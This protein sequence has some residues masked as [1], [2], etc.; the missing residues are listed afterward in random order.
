MDNII[1]EN[2]ER[3]IQTNVI[4]T[5]QEFFEISDVMMNTG[6]YICRGHS[7][8]KWK[9]QPS[10]LRP[11]LLKKINL[12]DAG[13][14][15]ESFL[16]VHFQDTYKHYINIALEKDDYTSILLIMQHY[17]IPTRLLDWTL[18]PQTALFFALNY[19]IKNK[20]STTSAAIWFLNPIIY[21]S[22]YGLPGGPY[23][24]QDTPDV[25]RLSSLAFLK[26]INENIESEYPVIFSPNSI[27]PRIIAQESIFSVHGW[28]SKAFEDLDAANEFLRCIIIK[29]D[30]KSIFYFI[31]NV[32][33][34][35]Y[36]KY[37]PDIY[38]FAEGL[39]R[40]WHK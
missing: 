34:L 18:N 21:R 12:I 26:N 13:L 11:E 9:L 17:G 33:K 23:R 27:F 20:N 39:K 38:G 14:N 5:Y 37:F 10:I 25:E 2:K 35:N 3:N 7:N 6:F 22:K 19:D 24:R 1:K 16:S 15:Y 32:L 30:D 4:T 40:A 29:D 8:C 28:S 31:N 36:E